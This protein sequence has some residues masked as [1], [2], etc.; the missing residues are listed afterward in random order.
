MGAIRIITHS[1]QPFKNRAQ[2]AELL[3]DQLSVYR[4]Q[5]VVV[6]GIPR[7]GVVVAEKLAEHLG[8]ELDIILSRK[9][10]APQN[11][12]LAIGSVS[13]TGKVYIDQSIVNSVGADQRYIEQEKQS[14]LEKLHQYAMKYRPVVSKASY[15]DKTVIVTDDGIATGAT[16]KSA[17]LAVRTENP[18]KLIA[19]VPVACESAINQLA[20]DVDELLCLRQPQVFY[21]ISQFFTYFH[22]V[23]DEQV[24]ELLKKHSKERT[25]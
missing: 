15:A 13:E 25:H 18:R 24:I 9:L 22:Q 5:K 1:D 4:G 7:G 11:P 2:A 8:A 17:L 20:G 6:L 14:Q 3:A 16:M 19:A 10:T 12:E 21:A 23:Q